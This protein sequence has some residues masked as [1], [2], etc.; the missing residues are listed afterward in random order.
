[1]RVSD[2][3]DRLRGLLRAG[4]VAVQEAKRGWRPFG[5]RIDE[6]AE[7]D[8]ETAPRS[9]QVFK[10]FAAEPVDDPALGPAEDDS[11][12]LLFEAG[13]YD[14]G[15]GAGRRFEWALTRQFI[16]FDGDEYDRMEQ[17]KL[18]LYFEP[19]GELEALQEDG[20]WSF[21]LPRDE[22]MRQVE[23]SSAFRHPVDHRLVPMQLEVRQEVV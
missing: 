3:E 5:R 6:P 22:F 12:G 8:G 1:M 7:L 15:D 11:D 19:V 17:L 14:W 2:A 23:A 10:E 21:G 4:G 16:L 9:W 13:T 18:V 20:I